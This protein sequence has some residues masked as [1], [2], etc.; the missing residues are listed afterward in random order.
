MAHPRDWVAEAERLGL[1]GD[2]GHLLH[3]S[4]DPEMSNDTLADLARQHYQNRTRTHELETQLWQQNVNARM[5]RQPGVPIQFGEAEYIQPDPE[6]FSNRRLRDRCGRRPTEH[7]RNVAGTHNERND[8]VTHTQQHAS[9]S[10][11]PAS[12]APQLIHPEAPDDQRDSLS[13]EVREK[14]GQE[15]VPDSGK[16]AESREHTL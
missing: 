7:G 15:N 8:S 14:G 12:Q 16:H 6:L 11:Q 3:Q 1:S 9:V 4:R 2:Q 5:T 10:R 13:Q